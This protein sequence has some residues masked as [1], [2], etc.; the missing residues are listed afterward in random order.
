MV[1]KKNNT[2]AI[3]GVIRRDAVQYQ[4]KQWCEMSSQ[5]PEYNEDPLDSSLLSILTEEE[6]EIAVEVTNTAFDSSVAKLEEA[7]ITSLLTL[8]TETKKE[9][10]HG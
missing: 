3:L 6:L 10:S 2:L 8:I 1:E 4:Y 5:Y 9:E 7:F